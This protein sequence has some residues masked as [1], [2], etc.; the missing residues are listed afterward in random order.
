MK[1]SLV[2]YLN[3][4]PYHYGL[5]N[6]ASGLYSELNI[7][8]PAVCARHFIEGKSDVA[9]VP[10]GALVNLSKY[11]TVLPYCISANGIVR[12]VLL[13]SNKDLKD[14]KNISPDSHSLSS[15]LL[16]KILC[17]KHWNIH[18]A[19]IRHDDNSADARVV[20]GDKAFDL[21]K[22]YKYS[23]IYAEWKAMTGLSFF[24]SLDCRFK[25]AK[26]RL[27][28]LKKHWSME[29]KYTCGC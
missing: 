27:S 9:L 6:A 24:C 12:S 17:H 8:N 19:F 10:V 2:S 25:C 15:N 7:V 5:I 29:F 4:Y 22:E 18:P 16:L 14:I 21:Q 28:L 20:I 13:L 3:S 1:I 23:L 26:D 11:Q